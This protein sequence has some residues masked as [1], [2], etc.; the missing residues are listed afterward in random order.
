MSWKG[1]E[2]RTPALHN[3]TVWLLSLVTIAGIG[4]YLWYNAD[5]LLPLIRVPPYQAVL[6]GALFGAGTLLNATEFW[7]L[8]RRLGAD[9][10]L[11]ENWMLYG[12]GQ[13]LNHAP[14]QIGTIYRF[15]YLRTVRGLP[16]SRSASGYGANLLLTVL[17]TGSLGIVATVIIGIRDGTWSFWLTTIFAG[18]VLLSFAALFIDL[19]TAK[20]SGVLARGWRGFREGWSE[21]LS[22]RRLALLVTLIEIVKYA[23]LAL[24]MQ[25]S[26]SWIGIEESYAFFL[27]LAAVTGLVTFLALTPA[28][29]GLRELAIGLT[30]ASLGV[31]FDVALMGA[32][33]DRAVMLVWVVIVG[34]VGLIYTGRKMA[35]ARVRRIPTADDAT[36]D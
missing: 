3:L 6:V 35:S 11:G 18:L 9:I 24:R 30:A 2:Q 32:T 22:H 17:S 29:I 14:G 36:S 19:P 13:L 10:G 12:A 16:F 1:P 23:I 31:E 8:Y 33:L 34:G 26:L 28:S 20:G 5:Q 27:I 7:L 4:L 21:I 15:E 25:L